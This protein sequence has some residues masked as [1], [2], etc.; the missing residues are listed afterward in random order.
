MQLLIIVFMRMRG[1]VGNRCGRPNLSSCRTSGLRGVPASVKI[2]HREARDTTLET[3]DE[4]NGHKVDTQHLALVNLAMVSRLCCK[5]DTLAAEQVPGRI[6][7]DLG[8]LFRLFIIFSTFNLVIFLPILHDGL[9][10]PLHDT[11]VTSLQ[12][13]CC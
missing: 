13:S 12:V 7:L 4:Q 5:R 1:G 11:D 3:S 8:T 10:H 2:D 6:F 9:L